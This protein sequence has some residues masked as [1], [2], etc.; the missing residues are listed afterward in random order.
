MLDQTIECR[1]LLEHDCTE[2]IAYAIF[3]YTVETK[4]LIVIVVDM[5]LIDDA[6]QLATVSW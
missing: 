6:L 2:S 1:Q 4:T 5:T 3:S